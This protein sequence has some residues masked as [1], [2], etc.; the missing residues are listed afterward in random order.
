MDKIRAVMSYADK[1]VLTDIETNVGILKTHKSKAYKPDMLQS[2]LQSVHKKRVINITYYSDHK[3]KT[4]ERK[5]EPV[6]I[7]FSRTNWY[8]IAFC[9]SCKDYRTFRVD[10]IQNIVEL[11]IP[12]TIVHPSL[13]SFLDNTKKT[14]DLDKIVIRV[15]KDKLSMIGEDKFY[16][17][18][19]SENA[20]EQYV[21]L[22]FLTFSIDKFARWYLSFAD[23]ATII[24]SD[25]LKD[26]IRTIIQGISF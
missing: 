7:F 23:F 9:L 25:K 18:L 12:H 2:I 15:D 21:E 10:R 14:Q 17:G 6:G 19:I 26:K 22:S 13:E 8:L 24:S 16:Y 5:I 20:T 4:S 1:D 3:Q 11:E